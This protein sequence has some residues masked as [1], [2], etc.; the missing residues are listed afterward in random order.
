MSRL[1]EIVRS[2]SFGVGVRKERVAVD[3]AAQLERA[4]Q[5][6]GLNQSELAARLGKTRAWVSKILHGEQNLTLGT[7]A[8]IAAALRCDVQVRVVPRPGAGTRKISEGA[9]RR[10]ARKK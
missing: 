4:L 10:S 2:R 7:I 8:E 1:A 3:V 5:S 6:S 9:R